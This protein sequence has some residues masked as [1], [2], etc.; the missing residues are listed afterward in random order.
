MIDTIQLRIL[1]LALAGWV[2]RQFDLIEHVR[3][4]NIDTGVEDGRAEAPA[5][6]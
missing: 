1:L 5:R 6:H 3:K 4:E 2:N